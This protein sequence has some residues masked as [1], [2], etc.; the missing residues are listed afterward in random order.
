MSFY[1]G[2]LEEDDQKSETKGQ[3]ERYYKLIGKNNTENRLMLSPELKKLILD[4]KNL[5]LSFYK[6]RR[7]S[8]T[9]SFEVKRC[10]LL[11]IIEQIY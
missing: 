1:R 2:S 10:L 7:L 9:R 8:N 6:N 5:K 11:L 4:D 3:I